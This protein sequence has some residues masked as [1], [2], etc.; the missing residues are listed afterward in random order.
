MKAQD[1]R[2]LSTK[3]ADTLIDVTLPSGAVWKL[4]QPPIQQFI[5]AGKLPSSLV[6]KL[7]AAAATDSDPNAAVKTLNPTELIQSLE[8]SRDL[9]LAC[10]VEPRISL[11]PK[12]DDE[13]AP[14]EILPEDFQFLMK[15]VIQG[16][17]VGESLSTFRPE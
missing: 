8:F 4:R 10:A 15:W 1:Y 5:A 7:A 9:L 6:G 14:E 16:G 17:K 12:S 3:K 13:I 11:N 2:K